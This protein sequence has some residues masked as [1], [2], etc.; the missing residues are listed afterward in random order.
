MYTEIV[1]DLETQK[2]FDEAHS[3]DPAD[4][5]VSIVSL[6]HRRLDENLKEID[7]QL[8]S[9]WFDQLESMWSLFANVDRVVGF[10]SLGFDVPVLA[11]LCPFNLKKLNHLDLMDEVKRVVGFRVSLDA[12]AQKTLGHTKTDSGINAAIYWQKHDETSLKKL[13]EYC[14]A[15]VL[16]TRDLY[17]HGLSHG[18]LKFIDRWNYLR[19]VKVDFSYPQ[20][21][22]IPQMGLF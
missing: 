19:Q 3:S 8:Y 7:G 2:L 11:P 14:Q 15:D 20:N 5:G 1:F 22:D 16:V 9:F 21:G 17:D 18:E 13:K 10:N 12:L 4:L 6:Y